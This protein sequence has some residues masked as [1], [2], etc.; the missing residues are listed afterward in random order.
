M[1][2]I[3]AFHN[4]NII[5]L[6]HTYMMNK[7]ASFAAFFSHAEQNYYSGRRETVNCTQFVRTGDC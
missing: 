5:P 4:A 7:L 2:K 6:E 1:I 3:D